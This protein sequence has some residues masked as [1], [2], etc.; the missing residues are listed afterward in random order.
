MSRGPTGRLK[1]D[2]AH[3]PESLGVVPSPRPVALLASRRAI[4]LAAYQA[5]GPT[6]PSRAS[7]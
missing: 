6:I 2:R 1:S 7:N 4:N 5:I 3:G